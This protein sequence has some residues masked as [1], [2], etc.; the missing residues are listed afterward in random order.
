M[1]FPYKTYPDIQPHHSAGFWRRSLLSAFV[2]SGVG[3]AIALVVNCTLLQI[4]MDSFFATYFGFLF[5]SIGLTI[6]WRLRSGKER[7]QTTAA[8]LGSA[9]GASK[10]HF[11]I[12]P[13]GGAADQD[14]EV[15]AEQRRRKH[16][17]AFSWLVIASGIICV[18]LDRE[19][20]FHMHRAL[21]IPIYCMLGVSVSL[22]LTFSV[23]DVVNFVFGLFQGNTMSRPVIESPNQIHLGIC[24]AVLM[25]GIFGCIFG[26]FDV[27]DP[28]VY[29]LKI[30]NLLASELY[31]Y[32]I[33]AALGAVGGFCNEYLRHIEVQ[34]SPVNADFDDDI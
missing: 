9:V 4:S 11:G 10:F 7:Q 31:C 20:Y 29:K 1:S 21:K 15:I 25:G 30:Q 18:G 14:P 27:A 22:A 23:I 5:V 13:G 6:L 32:K 33:G 34:Y 19:W 26:N 16:L 3:A 28:V 17:R 24:L 8:Q 12:S 2:G